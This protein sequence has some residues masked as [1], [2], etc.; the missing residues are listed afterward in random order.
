M[1][2]TVPWLGDERDAWLREI[3]RWAVSALGDRDPGEV[4]F[5]TVRARAW[6]TVLRGSTGGRVWYLKACTPGG[7]HEP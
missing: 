5:E 1:N 6:S 4:R 3:G 7:R 2:G